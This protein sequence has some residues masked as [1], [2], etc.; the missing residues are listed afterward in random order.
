MS[1]MSQTATEALE[2][3]LALRALTRETHVQT[4]CTQRTILQSLPDPDLAEVS[5]ALSKGFEALSGQG[6]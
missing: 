6:E 2:R 3:I 4:Y 5:L 1:T